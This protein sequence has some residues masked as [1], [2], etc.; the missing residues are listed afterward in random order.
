MNYCLSVPLMLSNPRFEEYAAEYIRRCKAAGVQ[1]IFLCVSMPEAAEEEKTRELTL[2]Q[3]YIP[4]LR[5]Q[6]FET[7][8]WFS[9]LGHGGTCEDAFSGSEGDGYTR[10]ERLEG[11]RSA[12][13]FCPLDENYRALVAGW[14]QRLARAGA[15]IILLDDDFR[16]SIRG[17]GTFCCC[18][19]HR[20]LLEK[21]LGEPFDAARMKKALEEG[22]PNPWRDAWLQVQGD[23]LRT[24]AAALRAALDAVDPSVRLAHCAVLSTWDA[25]GA[26]SLELAHIFAGHTRPLLRLIGAPYW[27][28]LHAFGEIRLPAVCEYERLQQA[29]CAGSGTELFCEGDVYPRPRYVVPSAYLEGFDQVMR[30]AGTSDGI[31]KYMFDYTSSPVY[32]TG[33]YDRHLRDLSVFRA[34]SRAFEGKRACGVRVFEPMKVLS[35][36]ADPGVWENR[37]LPAS[38]RFVTD[39]SLP[40]RY[41]A[42]PDAALVFGDAAE[43]ADDAVLAHGAIL[44]AAAA[45]ILTRRGFDVGAAGFGETLHPDTEYY[46]ADKE[47]VAVAGG[48]F[49]RLQAAGGAELLSILNDPSAE[50]A[51]RSAPGAFR[52]QNAAGQRFVVFA[53]EAAHSCETGAEHGL[54]RGWC[55]AALLRRQLPWLSGRQPDAVCD[56]APDLYMLARRGARSLTVALWNFGADAVFCPRVQL[57]EDWISLQPVLGKSVRSGRVVTLGELPAFGCACFTVSMDPA[58]EKAAVQAPE[59]GAP[60]SAP[61]RGRRFTL[62]NVPAELLFPKK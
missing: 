44:D 25:D 13:S 60:K 26:D 22:G 8:V 45:R 43:L 57:G 30:A 54:L 51:R 23:G 17:G 18:E 48:R 55:R 37:L 40:A 36:A 38:L 1:R 61:K 58:P 10:M 27:A 20:A 31:L 24:F 9:S 29:W 16:M 4:L 35:R 11:G 19:K 59:A 50:P 46:L 2:L 52:Y 33:Y 56:A 62:K 14:V 41:D 28:A 7:G 42:G 49:V 6:G 21:A 39:N 34:L 3:K 12:G 32:E 47:T 15:R 53:F 5:A